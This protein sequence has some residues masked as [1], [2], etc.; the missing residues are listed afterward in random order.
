[1]RRLY[2]DQDVR[3]VDLLKYF[4]ASTAILLQE[5]PGENYQTWKCSLTNGMFA[6]Y[7][8]NCSTEAWS[9]LVWREVDIH[10]VI[11]REAVAQ[12]T[13]K[14]HRNNGYS[15]IVLKSAV[16]HEDPLMSDRDGMTLQVYTMWKKY[17]Q[18]Q[19]EILNV[20]TGGLISMST[21]S[22]ELWHSN[23]GCEIHQMVIKKF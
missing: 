7:L 20:N 11:Y 12:F 18:S 6:I 21:F 15:K 10:G 9:F 22:G 17:F 16:D 23:D 19:A 5:F 2:L 3:A 4:S 13:D 14:E 1:M 8:G